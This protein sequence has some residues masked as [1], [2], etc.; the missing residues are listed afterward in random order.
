MI[1]GMVLVMYPIEDYLNLNAKVFMKLFDSTFAAIEKKMDLSI[2]RHAVL[3]SNIAN[4]ETP[5]YRAREYSF[6]NE[7]EKAMGVG[8]NPLKTTNAKHMDVSSN[9]SAHVEFDNSTAVGAD[10]NNVD[11]D[12]EMGK[13]SANSRDYSNA[14]NILATKLKLLKAAVSG[15]GGF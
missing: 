14:V 13:I 7:V 4:E 9:A 11:L 10:G 8:S 3:S 6:A 15:R 5:N 2:K 1:L 12:I